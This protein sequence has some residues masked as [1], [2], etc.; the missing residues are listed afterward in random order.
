MFMGLA[1]SASD[2]VNGESE[3]VKLLIGRWLSGKES[4]LNLFESRV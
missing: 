1:E 2:A 3:K 4:N